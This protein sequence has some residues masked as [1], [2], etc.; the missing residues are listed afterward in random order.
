MGIQEIF[1]LR[2]GHGSLMTGNLSAIA[3]QDQR[4]KTLDSETVSACWIGIS[5][6]LADGEAA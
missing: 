2:L 3:I 6:Q 5:L 1:Q 4:R